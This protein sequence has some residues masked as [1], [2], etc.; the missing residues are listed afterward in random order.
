MR[1]RLFSSS[2]SSGVHELAINALRASLGLVLALSLAAAGRAGAQEI[3]MRSWT[4]PTFWSSPEAAPRGGGD[5]VGRDALAV[6]SGR[7]ALAAGPVALPF[8]ALPPCRLVD[9]RGNGAPLSGGFLP[10]AT[11]RSYTLTGVCGLPANAQAVSL[12]ATVVKPVG[13]GFLVLY[14]QGGTF[15]PVS[16]LN[17]LGNDVIVNSAVV[18]LSVAGGISVALGVSGGDVILDTNGYYAAVPSVTSLNTLSGDLTLTAGTNITITPSGNS[19]TFASTG[20][21]SA[22]PTGPTGP[23]GPTG[24]T[25]ATGATGTAGATGA[26]GAAGATGATGATGAAGATGATGATG[27]A[28][29]AGATGATG[30]AGAPGATGATGATG[31]A[32]TPGAPGATGATGATGPAGP[33]SGILT[34]V[35]NV[36]T[37]SLDQYVPVTGYT[38]TGGGEALNSTVIPATCTADIRVRVDVPT[39]ETGGIL[40]ALRVNGLDTLTSC[41]LAPNATSCNSVTPQAIT[42]GD[43][44]SLHL[45]GPATYGNVAVLWVAMRCQ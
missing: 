33:G 26:T 6:S 16:T 41:T 14:P 2:S 34:G 7:Q 3:E 44:V 8:I 24:S 30:A 4:A 29:A 5:Q 17:F 25:G 35:N 1:P 13:P 45:T 22:G 31:S 43:I 21:G 20:G 28:G 36:S 42:A 11:V 15:P 19:L 27:A 37:F 18:P 38:F 10:A 23:Q 12:N 9:T 32:G 40:F 39:A